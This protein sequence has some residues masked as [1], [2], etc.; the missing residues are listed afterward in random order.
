M[1]ERKKEK[2]EEWVGEKEEEEWV[3]AKGGKD[4]EWGGEKEVRGKKEWG[5]EGRSREGRRERSRSKRKSG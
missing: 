2:K 4:E 5:G 3:K 1:K